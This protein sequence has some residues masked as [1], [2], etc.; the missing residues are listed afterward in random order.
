MRCRL[1]GCCK[2]GDQNSRRGSSLLSL[3]AAR[4]KRPVEIRTLSLPFGRDKSW[5]PTCC[6]DPPPTLHQVPPQV[7]E[8]ATCRRVFMDLVLMLSWDSAGFYDF[9]G[10]EG[11]C[12]EFRWLSLDIERFQGHLE[13]FE[14]FYVMSKGF[15]GILKGRGW[16]GT[17]VTPFPAAEA[18][19]TLL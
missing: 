7:L 17:S 2:G 19:T 12:P 11:V 4:D 6:F 15:S 13:G 5:S 9:W 16:K 10:F 1:G 3:A 14:G 8:S 18:H